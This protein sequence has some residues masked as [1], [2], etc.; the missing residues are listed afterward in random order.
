MDANPPR[1]FKNFTEEITN[2]FNRNENYTKKE[3]KEQ[4]LMAEEDHDVESP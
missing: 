3:L 4:E 2:K 1:A